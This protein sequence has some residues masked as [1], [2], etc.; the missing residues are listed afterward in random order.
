MTEEPGEL[1]PYQVAV[2]DADVD[3]LRRRLAHTRWPVAETVTD[4]SQGVRIQDLKALTDRWAQD[5]DWRR[6]ERK[7]NRYPHLMTEIDGVDIH[8]LHVRSEHPDALP[9]L[10][11]HGWPG[12]N[13]DFLKLIQPLVDPVA[14]G[15]EAADAFDVVAP[16]MPGFG[17]SGSPTTTGWTVQRTAA[18][19]I[20]LMRR[21]GYERWAAQGG[22][23]GAMVT[24]ALAAQEPAGLL[25]VHLHS[26]YAF[27]SAL[28]ETLDPDEQAAVDGLAR[29]SGELGGSNHLQ[30]TRPQTV[31]FALADSPVGQAAWLFEKYQAKT[32]NSGRV[33]DAISV[34]DMLDQI[35]LAWFTNTAASSARIYWENRNLGAS[36]PIVTLPVAV[37]VFPKDLPLP[38][39]HWIEA[40][41]PNLLLL[42][43]AKRGGHFAALEQPEV[44][45]RDLRAGL[46]ALR[47]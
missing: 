42:H 32:D 10:L 6:F 25:G 20:E 30:G 9:L 46:R 38:P 34:T 39:R 35:S 3:D 8:V 15:G 24:T 7:L 27:P 40:A 28:P 12:S 14:Y 47:S 17:F 13:A 5:Y 37:T 26:A 45:V 4:W 16:S 31:G 19:W 11:T 2:P 23:W 22:D 33:E 18:A 1:R 36:G 21:L 43:Q 41:Y 44:L 29:Y